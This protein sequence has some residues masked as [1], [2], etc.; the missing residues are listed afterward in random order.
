MGKRATLRAK[1]RRAKRA[2]KGQIGYSVWT[3]RVDFTLAFV[4]ALGVTFF[5]MVAALLYW[6]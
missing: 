3:K 6:P 1:R 2:A 4:L 5:A